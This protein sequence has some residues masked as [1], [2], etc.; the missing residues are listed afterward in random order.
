MPTDN[1]GDYKRDLSE[2]VLTPPNRATVSPDRSRVQTSP[3]APIYEPEAYS[4]TF[5][6]R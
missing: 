2:Y 6:V 3:E 4:R 1:S 5:S